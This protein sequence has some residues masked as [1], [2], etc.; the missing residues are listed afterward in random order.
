MRHLTPLAFA[1]LGFVSPSR[2]TSS[3]ED[4]HEARTIQGGG[5]AFYGPSGLPECGDMKQFELPDSW[6]L[7]GACALIRQN[8]RKF[9]QHFIV[10]DYADK[11]QK[12]AQQA[13][14]LLTDM[15]GKPFDIGVSFDTATKTQ[16]VPADHPWWSGAMRI[17]VHQMFLDGGKVEG[18]NHDH[19]LP[20]TGTR[21]LEYLTGMAGEETPTKGLSRDAFIDILKKAADTPIILATDAT[22]KKVLRLEHAYTVMDYK[23]E[24]TVSIWDPE[25]SVNEEHTVD[26]LIADAISFEHLAGFYNWGKGP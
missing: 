20:A 9:T 25:T 19:L 12:V 8:A 3:H 4:A 16:L 2:S 10:T 21:G 26:D 17:G 18:A 15:V 6:L 1:I 7:T 24:K 14:V 5:G 22:T 23:D 11:E 13:R